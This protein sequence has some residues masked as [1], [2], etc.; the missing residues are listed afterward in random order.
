MCSAA[1]SYQGSPGILGTLEGFHLRPSYTT[2][3]GW[4]FSFS[5]EISGRVEAFSDTTGELGFKGHSSSALCAEVPQPRGWFE[6]LFPAARCHAVSG[7]AVGPTKKHC[8]TALCWD[9]LI[10]T[11]QHCPAIN[12]TQG[13]WCEGRKQER[14][15]QYEA[16]Q[17][18]L[19]V[20][21]TWRHGLTTIYAAFSMAACWSSLSVT[22]LRKS[23][24]KCFLVPRRRLFPVFLPYLWYSL[25]HIEKGRGGWGLLSMVM[26][27]RPHIPTLAR[28]EENKSEVKEVEKSDQVQESEQ[29]S[30]K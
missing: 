11:W 8:S 5:V 28:E 18:W 1:L 26:K 12:P 17:K 24:G 6:P 15:V 21:L 19:V 2:K 30:R 4:V 22:P 10:F 16:Q 3:V 23:Q 9:P 13:R 14:K 27:C 25:Q 7:D 29:R 20:I